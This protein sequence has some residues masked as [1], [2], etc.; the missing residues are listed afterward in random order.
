MFDKEDAGDRDE[1][2]LGGARKSEPTSRKAYATLPSIAS[3]LMSLLLA[4]QF[5]YGLGLI[6]SGRC[7]ESDLTVQRRAS[8][9]T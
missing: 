6:G 8:S 3:N 9:P 4:R 1:R 7:V 5:A 2:E